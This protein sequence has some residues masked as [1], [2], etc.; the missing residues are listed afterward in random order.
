MRLMAVLQDPDCD[1][2]QLDR[3]IS[4]DLGVSFWLLRWI[5]SAYVSL[6]RKV[7]SVRDALVLLGVKNVR[8]WALLMTLAGIDDQPSELLRTAMT[9]AKMCELVD[10]ALGRPDL[11]AHFTVGLFSVVDTSMNM[12]MAD[13]LDELPLA[14]EVTAALLDQSGPL[15]KVLSWVLSWVLTYERGHFECLAPAPE[16]A[17]CCATPTWWRSASPTRRKRA[18]CPRRGARIASQTSV[19]RESRRGNRRN[20]GARPQCCGPRAA[21]SDPQRA[22]PSPARESTTPC[23]ARPGA[24]PPRR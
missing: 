7:T 14:P 12:R 8:S 10:K 18:T 21:G 23:C 20:S 5:N 22:D 9:R 19:T 11:D 6:P 13:A 16:A 17:P 4:N 2:E 3:A 24:R 1:L 15:G